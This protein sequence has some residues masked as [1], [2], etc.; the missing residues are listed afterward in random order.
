MILAGGISSRMKQSVISSTTIDPALKREAQSK[1]KAMISVDAGNRPFLDYLLYNAREAGYKDVLII[2]S[3][4][5]NSIRDYYGEKEYGNDFNGL[6]VSYAVQR[7][8][9][10]RSKPLGTADAVLQGLNVRVDWRGKKFTVCNS[11]N[12]YS[13]KA[14]RILLESRHKNAL[15]DY[16]RAALG[17]DPSRIL[18]FSITEKDENGFLTA[19]IE[20]PTNDD[21]RR[22]QDR[23]GP[24]G[25]S[26]NIF[27]LEYD[28]ILPFVTD[29]PIHPERN[30]KELPIAVSLLAH[31][32]PGSVY[33]YPL[34]ELVPDMTSIE[35]VNTV[36]K[37]LVREF[38]HFSW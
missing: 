24:I 25:V 6:N 8:P 5:D 23:K 10:G 20:K 4:K 22:A 26:M 7:V 19:I 28:D 13:Q 14:L 38:T 3:E 1:T 36:R 33:A 34:S 17:F 21:V 35:D 11:D 16:D 18:Q 12:L 29:L 9:A 37:Y 27:R 31:R 30:E 2:V 32:Y 15:I